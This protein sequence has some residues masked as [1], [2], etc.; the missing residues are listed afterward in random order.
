MS[1]DVEGY[2]LRAMQDFFNRMDSNGEKLYIIRWISIERPGKELHDIL[3]TRGMCAFVNK[4]NATDIMY[5]NITSISGQVRKTGC[6]LHNAFPSYVDPNH[7]C[8]N[9]QDKNFKIEAQAD[10]SYWM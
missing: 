2:E 10:E 5:L 1:L 6:N 7:V 3:V 4:N 8:D 9:I